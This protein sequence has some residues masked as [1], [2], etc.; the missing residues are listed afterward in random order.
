MDVRDEEV[1][2]YMDV[3]IKEKVKDEGFA[4]RRGCM[5]YVMRT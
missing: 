4:W 2:G 1:G 5:G 3:A